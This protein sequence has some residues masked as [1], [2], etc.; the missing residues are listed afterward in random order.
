M[1]E[2]TFTVTPSFIYTLIRH[3]RHLK[4]EHDVILAY[5]KLADMQSRQLTAK[6]ASVIGSD[7]NDKDILFTN[8]SDKLMP[9]A[10]ELYALVNIPD[11]DSEEE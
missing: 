1:K 4:T 9:L 2:P 3:S 8:V 5:A 7:K 10:K 6:E 11:D